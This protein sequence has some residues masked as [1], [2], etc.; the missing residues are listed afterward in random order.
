MKNLLV[1]VDMVNGFVN[2]G[3]LADKNINRIVPTIINLIEKAIKG[4][5]DIVAFKDCHTIDDE[6]FKIFPK[7][8][9]KGTIECELIPELLKFEKY[10][11]VI[12]KPTTNGFQTQQFKDIIEHNDYKN[13]IVCGCCT[14]ICIYNFVK[15]LSSYFNNNE[16]QTTILIEQHSVDTFNAPCHD[17]DFI[18]RTYLKQMTNMGAKVFNMHPSQEKSNDCQCL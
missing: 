8:C 5:Y 1:I 7:H 11:T 13:V 15:S 4:N 14:D 18:N 6:E 9:V 12:Q 2:E 17:A 16:I 3:N 10:M